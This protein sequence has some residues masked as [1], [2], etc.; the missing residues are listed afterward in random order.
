V[1][2]VVEE[3]NVLTDN[4]FFFF[5]W[6]SGNGPNTKSRMREKNRHST[7]LLEARLA[8]ARSQPLTSVAESSSL[9]IVGDSSSWRTHQGFHEKNQR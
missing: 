9:G 5:Y 3:G 1:G 7:Y 4:L 8:N 2:I 6:V